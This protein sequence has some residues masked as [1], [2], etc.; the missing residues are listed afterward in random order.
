MTE[1]LN[2][3]V[4]LFLKDGSKSSGTIS[5]VNSNEITLSNAFQSFNP[6]KQ[7]ANLNIN[8]SQIADLKVVQLPPDFY[9]KKKNGNG[10]S[11]NNGNNNNSITT[12]RSNTPRM[13]SAK[14]AQN[15]HHSYQSS[16]GSIADPDWGT[17][18]DVTN[19]KQEEFDFAANLAMFDKKSVFADFQKKDHVNPHDRL[20]GHNKVDN[21]NKIK[22]EKYDNDEMV[23]EANKSDNWDNIGSASKRMSLADRTGTSSANIFKDAHL[24]STQNLKLVHADNLSTIPLASP[25]QLLEIERL[26]AESYGISSAVMAEVCATNLSS[27]IAKSILGGSTRLSN[28]KNHNLPPLVLLLIG[29]ARCGSRAFATGRHLTNHGVRV[30]AFLINSDDQDK[31]LLQQWKLFENCGGKIITSNVHE[32]LDIVNHQLETPV[33]LIIDALQGYDD[34]LEDVF[35]QDED[36]QELRSLMKWCNEPH[37]QNKIMSFDVPSGI[38]GGSGTLSDDSLKLNSRWCVSMGLPITGL[39]LAYKNGHLDSG[40]V[41]HYLI[42]VGIPNKVYSSKSNLR[43]FDKF[44][45]SAESS[46]RLE[47][48]NE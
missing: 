34:H 7:L 43:K 5:E 27:L 6:S 47:L 25:V 33:E 48:S 37:Q 13:K 20:V 42:D 17:G 2:Y 44:W 3:R 21:V 30:L 18:S 4:D 15:I 29:S 31:D 11:N 35:F 16:A 38:D 41:Q 23:L 12:S 32:L 9:K 28:R 24:A 45:F 22:K 14:A 36:Q 19:I 10:N 26:S 1:F 8:S 46:I 39:I 40:D